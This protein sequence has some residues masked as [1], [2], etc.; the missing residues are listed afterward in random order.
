[1]EPTGFTG[2][3][4]RRAV[5]VCTIVGVDISGSASQVRQAQGAAAT[6]ASV[7]DTEGKLRPPT[8]ARWL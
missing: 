3:F 7:P 4:A 8:L 5:V 1:M 6:R 2:R